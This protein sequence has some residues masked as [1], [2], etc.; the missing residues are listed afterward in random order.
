MFSI[1][2]ILAAVFFLR[3]GIQGTKPD[4]PVLYGED[5]SGKPID[6]PE[7]I[8]WALLGLLMLWF[9]VARLIRPARPPHENGA[10]LR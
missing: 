8:G 6:W 4:S 10:R 9:G 5:E 7:R 2:Y 1:V 3:S